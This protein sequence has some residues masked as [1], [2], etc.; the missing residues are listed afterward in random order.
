MPA[1]LTVFAILTAKPGKADALRAALS[2]CVPPSRAEP[3]CISY[4]MHVATDDPHV[5]AFYET[6]DGNEGMDAH[7]QTPHFKTLME[8][9]A[10]LLAEE[11]M[12]RR[13]TKL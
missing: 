12:I 4:D 10:D 5:F 7:V 3:G 13:F 2:E 1:P 8:K 11:P 6:W 9:A